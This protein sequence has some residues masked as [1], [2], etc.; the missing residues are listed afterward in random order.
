MRLD[1]QM[2]PWVP[3]MKGPGGIGY[4]YRRRASVPENTTKKSEAPDDTVLLAQKIEETK[5]QVNSIKSEIARTGSSLAVSIESLNRYDESIGE[6][7]SK[8]KSVKTQKKLLAAAGIATLSGSVGAL[9]I[10]PVLAVPLG[11]IAVLSTLGSI[12]A[13]KK[14]SRLT[15]QISS[16]ESAVENF[17][18][19]QRQHENNLKDLNSRLNMEEKELQGFMMS[20]MMKDGN[21]DAIVKSSD[22]KIKGDS[23]IDDLGDAVSIG[24]IKLEKN[25]T[26]GRF[27]LI[28]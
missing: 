7:E 11:A 12:L 28:A 23:N 17:A 4:G 14:E 13:Y 18:Y 5:R 10:S 8:L 6:S 19:L 26:A 2:M 25:K 24:G 1:I 21:L 27:Q 9:T 3:T 15:D 22:V 16:D 20:K